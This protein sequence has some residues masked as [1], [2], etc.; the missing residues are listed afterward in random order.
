MSG[1]NLRPSRR[2]AA[3][4]CASALGGGASAT[5]SSSSAHDRPDLRR[6]RGTGRP[7]WP[8][9]CS[10]PGAGKGTRVGLLGPNSPDWVVAWLAATRIGAVVAMLNTY[11]KAPELR[12]VIRHA[13]LAT[14]LT[15]GELLGR[16]ARPARRGDARHRRPTPRAHPPPVAPVPPLG[17]DVGGRAP[18]V[19]RGPRRP[20]GAERRHRRRPARGGRG[21]GASGR[22]DG[23]CLASE[24]GSTADPKGAFHT[25][26]AVVRHAHNLWPMRAYP[27]RRPAYTPMPM[28]WSAGSASR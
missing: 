26:G 12:R 14:L 27:E 18:V 4:S 25:H 1:T 3:P 23:H 8:R 10:V 9:A 7:G 24:S 17:V 13:D 5:S 21:R 28:F 20:R 16:R 19:V 6:G 22:P 11:N 15:V 2:R